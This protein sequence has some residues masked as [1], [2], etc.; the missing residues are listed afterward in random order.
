[1]FQIKLPEENETRVFG[2]THFPL[3]FAVFRDVRSKMV[4]RLGEHNS[5]C[6]WGLPQKFW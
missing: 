3:R 6:G 1:M 5:F 4:L 2:P